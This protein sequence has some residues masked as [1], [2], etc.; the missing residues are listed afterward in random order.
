MGFFQ[1]PKVYILLL[2]GYLSTEVL[3]KYAAPPPPDRVLRAATKRSDL[4][5]R[6]MR[7]EKRYDAELA[8][9]EKENGWQSD[10]IFASQVRVS[11]EAPVFNLEDFEHHLQDVKC[12]DGKMRLDFVDTVSARDARH[13]CSGDN[14]GLIITSHASCNQEGERS[15]FEVRNVAVSADEFSLELSIV[16]SSWKRAFTRFNIDFG[17]TTEGHLL[18]RHSDFQKVRRRRQVSAPTT[19]VPAQTTA[20]GPLSVIAETPVSFAATNITAAPPVP[21]NIPDDVNSAS[22][23]LAFQTLNS[24]FSAPS[25]LSGLE[26]LV[27]IPT[28]PVEVGCKNCT[29]TGYILLTQGNFDVNSGFIPTALGNPEGLALQAFHSGFIELEANGLTAHIE[30]F[31][32][33]KVSGQ[34]ALSL[35]DLPIVGFSIPKLGKAGVSFN[36]TIQA[37]YEV[38]GGIE[39]TYGFDLWVPTNS[40]INIPF[41]DLGNAS[42][43]GFDGAEISALPFTANISDVELTLG[44]GFRPIIPV[45]FEFID[46][47][48]ESQVSVFMDLPSLEAKFST[49]KDGADSECNALPS[50]NSTNPA[51]STSPHWT[52][53][54]SPSLTSNSSFLPASVI[55]SLVSEIGPLVLVEASIN[56]AI[57]VGAAFR[58]PNIF[59]GIPFETS[60]NVFETNFPLPT[61]C[62]AAN[63]GFKPASEILQS[64]EASFISS[65]SSASVASSQSQAAE[66]SRT[67]GA[68]GGTPNA[69]ITEGGGQARQSDPP[70]NSG[71]VRGLGT[72]FERWQLVVLALC[73]V[74]GGIIIFR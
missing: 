14:G 3:A 13:A 20:S 47:F 15:V 27:G 69:S 50:N 68:G 39:A 31:S 21:T 19:T 40:K 7:I 54:T 8:Y 2:A 11:S 10:S 49:K 36:A 22:F 63:S 64:K 72:G 48:I 4:F 58:V 12:E 42:K 35:F 57:G 34:F 23:N 24:T 6:S 28:L 52:N 55:P 16:E 46:G 67:T 56:L 60:V 59:D 38:S 9:I 44:L 45:G 18:R 66:A 32:K 74:T 33:P 37:S 71:G 73:L 51:N 65:A 30:L 5:R 62:L 53:Q 17:Y 70:G 26:D 29:T 1:L 61:A 41:P 43:A 25:F